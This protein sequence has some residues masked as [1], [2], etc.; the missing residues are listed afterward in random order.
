MFQPLIAATTVNN[1]IVDNAFI[2]AAVFALVQWIIKPLI[3]LWLPQGS[4]YQDNMTRA[5]GFLTAYALT[6]IDGIVKGS[7]HN[8]SDAWNLLPTAAAIYAS[9]ALVYHISSPGSGK[10]SA[11][12]S[13]PPPGARTQSGDETQRIVDA[14][15]GLAALLTP[16]P[17]P[18]GAAGQNAAQ[19]GVVMAPSGGNPLSSN[20]GAVDA[21]AGGRVTSAPSV[22][23]AVADTRVPL[24]LADESQSLEASSVT[25][26]SVLTSIPAPPIGAGNAPVSIGPI[27]QQ[28]MRLG[29]PAVRPL[30]PQ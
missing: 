8:W 29:R 25:S 10:T 9:S 18:K 26:A 20:S 19:P 6:W 23:G 3:L 14:I 27:V 30:A 2:A 21:A 22:D 15:N 12:E 5:A 1:A 4:P 11:T 17:Q 7:I 13:N 24:T 28:P 16:S